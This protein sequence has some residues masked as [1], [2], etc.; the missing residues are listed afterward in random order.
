M[1]RL[2]VQ[3]QPLPDEVFLSWF[4]RLAHA[5]GEGIQTLA[6]QLWGRKRMVGAGA[7]FRVE[8]DYLQPVCEAT[9]LTLA[10]VNR[11]TIESF[12]GYL[13]NEVQSKGSRRWVL[14]TVDKYRRSLRYGQQVCPGCLRDDPIAYCR[15]SWRLAFHVIC[16]EHRAT[17]I[18]RCPTCG[19][20]VLLERLDFGMFVPTEE[21]VAYRCWNCGYDLRDATLNPDADDAVVDYQLLLLDCLRRGWINIDGRVVYSTQF[22]DGL[23]MI[24]SLIGGSRWSK[25]LLG[26]DRK[27]PPCGL[28]DRVG[29]QS[30]SHRSTERRRELLE[31]TGAYLQEWPDLF[32]HDMSLARISGGK[33]F[34]FHNQLG[35]QTVPFWLWEPV[36]LRLDGTMYTPPDEEIAEAIRC[37]YTREGRVRSSQVAQLLNMR[38]K[39]NPRVRAMCRA[40]SSRPLSA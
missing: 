2:P 19:S 14:P 11:L 13:W 17:L 30:I 38:S 40:F 27:H 21:A 6:H 7:A 23:W 16:P 3:V 12:V 1:R 31:R 29:R 8:G 15:K 25:G 5:H 37:V 39:S 35:T 4:V 33:L 20:P 26:D 22:F 32:L 10:T 9:G 36:H 28:E 34:R 24:W 18:D